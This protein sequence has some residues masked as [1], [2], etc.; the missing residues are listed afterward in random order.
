MCGS[1]DVIELAICTDA[2]LSSDDRKLAVLYAAAQPAAFGHGSSSELDRERTW[3][4]ERDQ[5]CRDRMA[6]PANGSLVDCLEGFYQE[7]IEELA[8]AD[9]FTLPDLALKTLDDV[10]PAEAPMYRAM[11]LYATVDDPAKRRQAVLPLIRAYYQRSGG[12]G[13]YGQARITTLND[14]VA[15]DHNFGLFVGWTWL[16]GDYRQIA[17]PCGVLARRPALIDTMGFLWGGYIDVA[18]PG[19]DC[20][21]TGPVIT[22][23][24]ELIL[25]AQQAT[26][27]CDGTIKY[28][29]G[30]DFEKLETAVRLYRPTVW[31]QYPVRTPEAAEMK[32]RLNQARQIGA[33]KATLADFY[34]ATFRLV[35]K[36]ATHQAALGVD[37]LVNDAFSIC[38]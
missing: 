2:G 32:F 22:G 25:L 37:H 21:D 35:R 30:R 6:L 28:S 19:T 15:S 5:M 1:K 7:R 18:I 10:A 29:T 36:T 20:R 12:D 24:T 17:W 26:P 23:L 34:V 3:L 16:K 27:P 38:E 8:R 4:K 31:S 11:V 9:V 13:A 14:T 33:V